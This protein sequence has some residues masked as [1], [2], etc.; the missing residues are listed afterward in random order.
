MFESGK[1]WR[2]MFIAME[3]GRPWE[4]ISLEERRL[5]QN[6]A[7]GVSFRSR[8]PHMKGTTS[9]LRLLFGREPGDDR[10]GE[11][12]DLTNAG[13]QHVMACYALVNMRLCS[14]VLAGTTKSAA[15]EV[16][17]A[18]C[19]KHLTATVRALDPSVCVLQS[20]QIRQAIDP[21]VER[22]DH[23]GEGLPLEYADFGG[24]DTLI[25]SFPHPYQQ[26]RNSALSWGS[27]ASTPYL[28]AVVA[29]TLRAARA[30][31]LAY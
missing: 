3:V 7:I 19:L 21:V 29:P 20:S 27:S 26:G 30:F 22:L 12:L 16:M 25:A 1:P 10:D 17:S 31:G 14:A 9:A 5:D 8:K 2:V 6:R 4:F 15:T 11:I 24:V 13:F 23:V 18:N 28:N